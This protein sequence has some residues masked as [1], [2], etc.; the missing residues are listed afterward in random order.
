MYTGT[1][2][3][4]TNTHTPLLLNRSMGVSSLPC[5]AHETH[6]VVVESQHVCLKADPLFCS[7]LPSHPPP[8]P[9]LCLETAMAGR[10]SDGFAGGLA[11][12]KQDR[13]SK[14]AAAAAGSGPLACPVLIT[15]GK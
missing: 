4:S 7:L 8:Q 13:R 11:A 15:Y 5:F 2:T 14:G 12:M 10:S 9:P 6:T 3:D 1:G